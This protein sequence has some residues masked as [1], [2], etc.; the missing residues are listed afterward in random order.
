[1]FAFINTAA[2]QR[3][4]KPVAMDNCSRLQ[5]SSILK[6]V[7]H[8]FYIKGVFRILTLNWLADDHNQVCGHAEELPNTRRSLL[9]GVREAALLCPIGCS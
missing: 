2:L 3:V 8:F 9:Q 7:Q 6:H 5:A 4:K 1:M